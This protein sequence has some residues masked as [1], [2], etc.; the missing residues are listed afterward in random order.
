MALL[1]LLAA[2]FAVS[3]VWA[4]RS[5]S[6]EP[7]R[8]AD[9]SI[10]SEKAKAWVQ[11][12]FNAVKSQNIKVYIDEAGNILSNGKNKQINNVVD[13]IQLL[14]SDLL[15]GKS[16]NKLMLLEGFILMAIIQGDVWPVDYMHP[17]VKNEA[18]GGVNEDTKKLLLEA[19]KIAAY[20]MTYRMG[21]RTDGGDGAIESASI[22]G[23]FQ[24]DNANNEYY[25]QSNG[26]R[27][28]SLN[29]SRAKE[30]LNRNQTLQAKAL[31]DAR[32]IL[33]TVSAN[34]PRDPE[35]LKTNPDTKKVEPTFNVMYGNNS[36]HKDIHGGDI[37]GLPNLKTIDEV[38]VLMGLLINKPSSPSMTGVGDLFGSSQ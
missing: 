37:K 10:L 28:R 7:A 32:N 24:V 11:G 17:A 34:R 1:R 3:G 8:P 19:A 2:V 6:P 29:R 9:Q 25:Y 13:Y 36:K 27:D 21:L 23:T 12:N 33:A 35:A 20:A 30:I 18:G 38:L 31:S 22:M 4:S 5:S 15:F 26:K 14:A 16:T